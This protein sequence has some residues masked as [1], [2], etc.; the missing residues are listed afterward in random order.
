MALGS[1]YGYRA[2]AAALALAAGAATVLPDYRLAPEHPYPAALED[3][4]RA[5]RRLLARGL[6]PHKGIMAGRSAGGRLLIAGLPP[7]K[8]QGV[9][10]PRGAALWWP[11]AAFFDA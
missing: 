4:E 11:R 9:P 3:I 5:Y 6:P 8:Q 10:Q 2:L 7:V 1:A